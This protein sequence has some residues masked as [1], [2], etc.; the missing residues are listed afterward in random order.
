MGRFIDPASP[1]FDS[2]GVPLSGG[3]LYFYATGATT[4]QNTW[5][6]KALTV[7]NANPILLNSAGRPVAEIWLSPALYYK[8]AL[9]TSADVPVYTRDPVDSTPDLANTTDTALG[10]ALVGVKNILAGGVARTQH[11]KNADLVN[12]KDFGAK[13]D[14]VTNDRAA[15]Q[16]ALDSGEDLLIPRG[17]GL[18][19]GPLVMRTSR[20]RLAGMGWGSQ[21]RLTSTNGV[22]CSIAIKARA[23]YPLLEDF[24]LQG[25]AVSEPVGGA[26]LHYQHDQRRQ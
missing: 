13:F 14:G 23:L 25:S 6:D 12:L 10:D 3:K 8:V 2:A 20:Q 22:L 24:E 18:I 17:L 11:Q 21:I 9:T 16:S 19:D 7:L 5:S 4:P 15:I 1:L 26:G